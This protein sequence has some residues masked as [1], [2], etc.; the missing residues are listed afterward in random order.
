MNKIT[1]PTVLCILF[2][3]SFSGAAPR[4]VS[5]SPAIDNYISALNAE[6][7][8]VGTT[9]YSPFASRDDITVVGDV[10]TINIESILSLNPTQVVTTPITP[11]RKIRTLEN[12]GVEV[13]VFEKPQ[14]FDHLCE[15]FLRLA[16]TIDKNETA[17]K[18]VHKAR[19]RAEEIH[20][21]N[22]EKEPL[23]VFFQIGMDPLFTVTRHSFIHDYMRFSGCI[24]IAAEA[25]SGNY[26]K[27]EVVS[28]N[29][30]AILS[31]DMGQE[32]ET[33]H[34]YW[35]R[36]PHMDAVAKGRIYILPADSIASPDPTMFISMLEK[37]DTL[38]R[39]N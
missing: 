27:E 31:T 26:S 15:Q 17:E 2:F 18:T 34:A 10:L 28:S 32:K 1:P 12:L 19:S 35:E 4:I 8:L 33:I 25:Q 11:E 24:N 13:T 38:L 9:S 36:F 3:C 30:F 7:M 20:A 23:T 37:I 16:E 29:P 22:A 14:S 39:S 21:Q 6:H 5:L